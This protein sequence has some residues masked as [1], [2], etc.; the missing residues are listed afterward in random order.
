MR[1]RFWKGQALGNDYLV[2][3]PRELDFPLTPRRVR[4]LCDRQRG[5]GADG[6]LELVASK[7]ADFGLRIW[8]PDGSRAEKSGNG[9]RIFARFLHATGRT[10]AGG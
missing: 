1:N 6:V 7:R 5:V 3:D 10:G 9:L 2:V 8:N 4:A